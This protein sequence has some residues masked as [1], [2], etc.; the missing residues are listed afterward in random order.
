VKNSIIIEKNLGASQERVLYTTFTDCFTTNLWKTNSRFSHF[1]KPRYVQ[2]M[3]SN[4]RYNLEEFPREIVIS[5]EIIRTTVTVKSFALL[6]NKPWTRTFLIVGL[7]QQGLQNLRGPDSEA[8]GQLGV[9]SCKLILRII[10]INMCQNKKNVFLDW[11][12][13]CSC[14]SEWRIKQ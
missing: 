4:G 14:T 12:Q 11:M 10:L 13:F 1:S 7:T 5:Y 9:F 6:R 3:S 8:H 2:N